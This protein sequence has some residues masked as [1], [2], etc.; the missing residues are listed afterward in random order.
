ML[1]MGFRELNTLQKEFAGQAVQTLVDWLALS[2]TTRSWK[3]SRQIQSVA[4]DEPAADILFAEH[5]FLI[6]VQHHEPGS[7]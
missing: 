6:P 7:H 3:P 1:Y 4:R 5:W 2:T